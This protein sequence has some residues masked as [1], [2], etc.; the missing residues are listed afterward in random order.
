MRD[1]YGSKNVLYEPMSSAVNCLDGE[2]GSTTININNAEKHF[3]NI[4]KKIL[5]FIEIANPVI[6]QWRFVRKYRSIE[7][8]FL[9]ELEPLLF[10]E[11]LKPLI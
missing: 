11:N 1:I 10:R 6:S 8:V 4:A 9:H 2:D 3:E 5:Y 7:Y